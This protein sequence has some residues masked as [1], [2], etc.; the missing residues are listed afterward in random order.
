MLKNKVLRVLFFISIFSCFCTFKSMKSMVVPLSPLD[1]VANN[2]IK[3]V[4][5]LSPKVIFGFACALKK[6]CTTPLSY[7]NDNEEKFRLLCRY[8]KPEEAISF[9]ENSKLDRYGIYGCGA[10]RTACTEDNVKVVD[11]LIKKSKNP[12]SVLKDGGSTSIE[13]HNL[14]DFV[15]RSG[16]FK[17]AKYLIE[18]QKMNHK[19]IDG[20]K[21]T[22]LC[23]ACKGGNFDLVKYIIE[24]QGCNSNYKK[25]LH[26]ACISTRGLKIVKWLVDEKGLDLFKE[27]EYGEL[28]IFFA[29]GHGRFDIVKWMIE[30]KGVAPDLVVKKDGYYKGR[31]LLIQAFDG[32]HPEVAMYLAKM[33]ANTGFKIKDLPRN[34]RD[35]AE[36]KHCTKKYKKT[37]RV[38]KTIM[39]KHKKFVESFNK[40][41]KELDSFCKTYDYKKVNQALDAIIKLVEKEDFLNLRFVAL[42]KVFKLHKKYPN[43]INK[44]HAKKLFSLTRFN[45]RLFNVSRYSKLLDF[46]IKHRVKDMAGKS[47]L[48]MAV[49]YCSKENA[50]K[51]LAKIF[52]RTG[53][54]YRLKELFIKW[55]NMFVKSGK[56][57]KPEK[58]E[59]FFKDTLKDVLGAYNFS[60][61]VLASYFKGKEINGYKEAENSFLHALDIAKSLNR[62]KAF[63]ALKNLSLTKDRLNKTK[64]PGEIISKI[65]SYV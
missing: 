18:K 11:W 32:Q 65:M 38:I 5:K 48:E 13:G 26:Y 4:A 51:V 21:N 27:I 62:K 61:H 8:G 44:E 7:Y 22:P 29:V 64:L 35:L 16:S 31:S 54:L 3:N 36:K 23:Y 1:F 63:K 33:G 24:E 59:G 6:L 2:M 15:C 19:K 57:I 17:V 37:V 20:Y 60:K 12:K 41:T 53:E 10:I 49:L 46:A 47:L 14:L 40:L 52:T 58:K 42:D 39:S 30:Q 56:Y 9:L 25:I 43:A 45:H 50:S 34:K 28:P 55:V